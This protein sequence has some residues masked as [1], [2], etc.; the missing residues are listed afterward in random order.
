MG[1]Q[2]VLFNISKDF[3]EELSSLYTW[4]VFPLIL[5]YGEVALLPQVANSQFEIFVLLPSRNK[6][7]NARQRIER[8]NGVLQASKSLW[9]NWMF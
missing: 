2:S 9:H 3:L 5:K 8:W 7:V 1:S 4:A 6:S